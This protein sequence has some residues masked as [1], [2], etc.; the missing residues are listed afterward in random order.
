MK[1]ELIATSNAF[2][3]ILPNRNT[4]NHKTSNEVSF[5]ENEGKVIALFKKQTEIIR[6]DVEFALSVSQAMS[7][8]ILHGL[9]NKG[10]IRAIGGGKKTRYEKTT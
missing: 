5:T 3:I 4:N 1:P 9:I 6:K 8:R 10:A 7:V 2:K